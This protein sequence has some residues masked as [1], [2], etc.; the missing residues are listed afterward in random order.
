MLDFR[1][2]LPY[3]VRVDLLSMKLFSRNVLKHTHAVTH[4]MIAILEYQNKAKFELILNTRYAISGA[5]GPSVK[6]MTTKIVW[7]HHEVAWDCGSLLSSLLGALL[8]GVESRRTTI[9]DQ[10]RQGKVSFYSGYIYS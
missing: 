3:L 5:R 7:L 4:M 2:K 10:I 1:T 8:V 6:T 9:T